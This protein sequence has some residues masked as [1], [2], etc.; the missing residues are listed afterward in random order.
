MAK[1][2]RLELYV[3]GGITAVA[4]AV[5]AAFSTGPGGLFMTDEEAVIA[6]HQGPRLIVVESKGCGWCKRLRDDLAPQYQQSGEHALAPLVYANINGFTLRGL[7]LE[8]PVYV[9]PTLLM[10][11]SDGK[12]LGRI[13]GYPGS[14]DRMRRFVRQHTR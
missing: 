4:F 3:L 7:N 11:N 12:E 1:L 2:Q 9:T 6:A 8:E 5:T 10:V 14:F 13:R